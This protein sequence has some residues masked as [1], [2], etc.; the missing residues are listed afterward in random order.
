MVNQP[1]IPQGCQATVAQQQ[2]WDARGSCHL[3]MLCDAF[4]WL[5]FQRE[6]CALERSQNFDPV[7]Q[8]V[9]DRA[10]LENFDQLWRTVRHIWTA[11]D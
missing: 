5:C 3:R 7:V 1:A 9:A 11:S 8:S 4:A 10:K 2:Q 6:T